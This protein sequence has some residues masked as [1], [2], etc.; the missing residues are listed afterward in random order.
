[1]IHNQNNNIY[2]SKEGKIMRTIALF[3]VIAIF[4]ASCSSSKEA[5][6]PYDE[7]YSVEDPGARVYTQKSA[8]VT[9]SA[10]G[11]S[12]QYEGDYYSPDYSTEDF[13][14]E[15]YYD[16]EYSSRIKRFHE[17]NPGYD[18]YDG[19]YTD[20]Y[21]YTND[22]S[23]C[24][25]N[26]YSG[27][28]CCSPCYSCGGS[29]GFSLSIGFGVG[30]GWGWGGYY[31]WRYPYYSSYYYPYWGYYPPY[32]GYYPPYWGYNSYWAGYWDGWYAAGGDYYNTS[33]YYYGPRTSVGRSSDGSGFATA[34]GFRDPGT[35]STDDI[36]KSAPASATATRSD[37]NAQSAQ[38]DNGNSANT[39]SRTTDVA[40]SDV[41]RGTLQREGE[42]SGLAG[43]TS[44]VRTSEGETTRSHPV[45]TKEI[46]RGGESS[47][48]TA[49]SLVDRMSPTVQRTTETG[50]GQ[51]FA[52][53]TRKV[54]IPAQKYEKPRSYT[55]PQVRTTPSSREYASPSVKSSRDYQPGE[56]T[57]RTY[58]AT[59]E[60]KSM[61]NSRKISSTAG[62]V[63][64]N[65]FRSSSS[66]SSSISTPSSTPSRSYSRPSS[67]PS[68]SISS[69]S[70]SYSPSSGSRSSGSVSRGGGG[71]SSGSSSRGG[72]K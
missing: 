54:E 15:G 24:G 5:S 16:Y 40:M 53:T 39:L 64:S 41:Q 14:A 67:T 43:P 12:S 9:S 1:M 8:N 10:V 48:T 20:S 4:L 28:G 19:Y 57:R 60:R 69:P 58:Y 47:S 32:Y 56:S 30:Y 38:R 46:S 18:Y 31:G 66:R 49:S 11:G 6:S 45:P 29:S 65:P 51:S 50:V 27:C 63:I 21:R 44:I 23:T 37:I 33:T 3:I 72:R 13:D 68:R 59:P 7:V 17:P 52:G 26:I 22:Y 61:D 42:S 71:G 55:G 35:Y 34:R 2:K 62:K 70:R 25:S 36:S